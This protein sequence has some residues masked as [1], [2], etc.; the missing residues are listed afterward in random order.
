MTRPLELGCRCRV[1]SNAKVKAT[2]ISPWRN[3]FPPA[4]PVKAGRGFYVLLGDCGITAENEA[5]LRG[6]DVVGRG[7]RASQAKGSKS[8]RPRT[9][10]ILFSSNPSSR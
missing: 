7:A 1:S 8:R 4:R 2:V 6:P 9:R 10:F 3:G 5:V